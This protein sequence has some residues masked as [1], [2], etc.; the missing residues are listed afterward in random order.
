[1]KFEDALVAMRRGCLVRPGC[2][3]KREIKDGSTTSIGIVAESLGEKVLSRQIVAF[4]DGC[5]LYGRDDISTMC[6]VDFLLDEDWEVVADVVE[7]S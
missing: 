7:S 4:R 2:W 3:R 1:M 5:V 6:I